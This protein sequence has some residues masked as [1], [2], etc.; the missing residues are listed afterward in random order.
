MIDINQELHQN[1]L[2]FSYE[3]N[4]QRAFADA[5]DGLK[6]GQRAC[7]W[8][9]Y[10]KK[11]VSNKPHVKSAK[12]SGGVV[13]NWWPH[14]TSAIYDTFARM[15]QNWVNNIPEV[16]WHGANGSIQ[17]SGEA[18]AD[19]YTEARLSKSTEDG[20][21]FN[22][23]KH[24]VPMKLNF[25]ED[26]EWPVVFP[27]IY[28]RLMVNGCQGIGSTVANV[29]LPHNLGELTDILEKYVTTGELDYSKLAPDFPT[30]GIIINSKD[31][32]SIYET[33]KGKVIL[34]AKTEIKGNTIYITEVTYQTYVE[35]LIENI[36]K[37]MVN[38]TITDIINIDNKSGKNKLLI[39][40]E[41][42]KNPQAVLMQLYKETDLQKSFSANQFAL[43]GKTPKLLNLK[44]Y[45]DIFIKHNIECINN[46]Y[47]YELEKAKDR[48]EIVEG[49]L[50]ALEDIDNIITLIKQSDSAS[51]AV[52]RLIEKYKM[53][54]RQAKAIVDM[55]LGRLAK[56]EKIEL[57]NEASELKDKISN[58]EI[59]INDEDKK[60]NIFLDRIKAFTKKYGYKRRTELT[61]IE[62]PKNK[63]EK[64]VALIPPE[65]CVVV[66]TEGGSLKRIPATSFRAQRKG[67]KGVKTQEDITAAVIRTNTV[68]SLMIFTDKGK[69]YRLTVN[70]IPEGT[71]TSRGT[72]VRSLIEMEKD[73]DVQTIYSIYRDTDA[74]YVLFV[75]KKGLVK[76][77]AL[78]EYVGTKKSKGIGAI[79]LKEGDTLSVVTLVKD[80][81]IVLLSK[82]G[83]IIRFN[84]SEI[85]ATGRLTGGVK[86]INLSDD[87][88]LIAALPIRHAE[89]DIAIFSSKGYGKKVPQ[90]EIPLQ[91]RAG[92]GVI[93]YKPNNINGYPS[94]AQLVTDGDMVLLVGE[95]NSICINADEIPE[96]GRTAMGNIMMK[97][98]ILSASKV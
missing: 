50:K 82:N 1:F 15:S 94:A 11:Y 13:A 20:L 81:Q 91:K 84:T 70:N 71:N 56:L 60:K 55:K 40:I 18:A 43:V 3:A 16:D 66:M 8:E 39:E 7:L 53:S 69:M 85:S 47:K 28:P 78:D 4:S 63:E 31:L 80:E 79:N 22:I 88:E 36:K 83:Y 73:E 64:E 38:N 6:P 14:G 93:V 25:S 42:E 76:K 17:I 87:D 12:I 65:K 26:D 2:D 52:T 35:P 96:M 46:E 21:L 41:C 58:C 57:E 98:A 23:N 44:Q 75:T 77:T 90:S 45:F 48:L 5:R 72:P 29:W 34:Q 10:S 30:G 61:H 49:L 74:K 33:G 19:R 24:T 27:A 51:H 95:K 89:D 32:H 92:K 62:I 9:M 59:V 68:D 86:G 67:G 54:E 97:G 37:L